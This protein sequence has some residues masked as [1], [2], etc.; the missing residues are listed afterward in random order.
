MARVKA[1]VLAAGRG[2]R[3]GGRQPKTLLPL[4]DREPMLHHILEGLAE[5][6]ITD[7]MVVTGFDAGAV[8]TFVDDKWSAGSVTYVFNA[9]YASWGNFHSVRVALDQVPGFDALV[10]NSDIVI[11]PDVYRR[12]LATPGDLVLAVQERPTRLLDQ[13]DMRVELDRGRIVQIGKH[14]KLARSHGEYA[15]VS[16]VRPPAARAYQ[17]VASDWEWR[18]NTG[19]YY[20]DVY[21]AI[22]NEVDARS[23]KVEIGEYAEVD[24]PADVDR[25]VAI[26]ESREATAQP[27]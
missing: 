13:E 3:M 27:A 22:L 14:V 10:V 18:A 2:V 9:R 20:E 17:N 7:L 11:A 15:G 6:G 1:I 24:V 25:A 23:A 16:L 8:Q 4:G 19:G 12:V 5:A 26:L 21:A